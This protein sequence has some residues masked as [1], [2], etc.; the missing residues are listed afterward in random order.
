[1]PVAVL[2]TVS[3]VCD[4]YTIAFLK[5][6]YQAGEAEELQQQVNYYRAGIDWGNDTLIE[7][8]TDLMKTNEEQWLTEGAL[9][10][11]EMDESDLAT[12][13]RLALQVRN[14]N[15]R[16]CEIKN[17]ICTLLG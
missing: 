12:I 16:R 1:M 2:M 3:K 11:G 14:I 10:R 15:R 17:K 9:R 4:R 8:T 13:G 6:K 7:L 5:H